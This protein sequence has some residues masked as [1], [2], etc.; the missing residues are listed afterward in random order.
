VILC[1]PEPAIELKMDI[2]GGAADIGDGSFHSTEYAVAHTTE[3][4]WPV[5]DND[6]EDNHTGDPGDQE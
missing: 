1:E 6:G 4:Q 3:N 5:E 2:L